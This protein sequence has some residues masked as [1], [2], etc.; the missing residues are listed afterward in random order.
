MRNIFYNVENWCTTLA[1]KPD[2]VCTSDCVDVVIVSK[3]LFHP[4]YRE[5]SMLKLSELEIMSMHE[6]AQETVQ[7]YN[8]LKPAVQV[9]ICLQI[10]QRRH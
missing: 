3:L 4:S 7:K 8:N 9:Q 5:I 2:N 1:I 10:Q 6:Y